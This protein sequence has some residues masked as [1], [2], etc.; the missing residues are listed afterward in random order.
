MSQNRLVTT[1]L[2]IYTLTE[3]STVDLETNENFELPGVLDVDIVT[4]TCV[5]GAT[6][7]RP[8]EGLCVCVCVC[9]WA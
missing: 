3:L 2:G 4:V 6:P 9:Q 5:S 8:L 7:T 1:V